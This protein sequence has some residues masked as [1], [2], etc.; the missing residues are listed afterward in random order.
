MV[1][2]IRSN[3]LTSLEMKKI[4]AL[5]KV[6]KKNRSDTSSKRVRNNLNKTGTHCHLHR[7]PVF[8]LGLEQILF[9]QP[10]HHPIQ[11]RTRY[12]S[13]CGSCGETSLNVFCPASWLK[14]LAIFQRWA[15][16]LEGTLEKATPELSF[17]GPQEKD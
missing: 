11:V 15:E 9:L 1:F 4:L 8:T 13:G 16:A 10:V 3:L 2:I 5:G 17:K 12:I 14:A 6:L 7:A